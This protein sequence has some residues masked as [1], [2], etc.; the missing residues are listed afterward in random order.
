MCYKLGI[1]IGST[2]IKAV[3]IDETGALIYSTY[4]RHGS[5]IVEKLADIMDELPLLLKGKTVKV[6]ITGSA[7]MSLAESCGI[8][9]VQEVYALSGAVREL[10]PETDVVIEL[11]GEDAKILF[12]TGGVEERMNGTCAGGTGAFIDQ[13]ATLLNVSVEELDRLAQNHKKIYPIAS[14]CGVFAK[15]DIQPLINQGAAKED[16]AASIYQAVAEQTITGLAQGRR[17]LGRVLF[18][19]GPLS[20]NLGLRERFIETLNLSPENAVFP[21][22]GQYFVAL[23]AAVYADGQP[24]TFDYKTLR[25]VLQNQKALKGKSRFLPPLFASETEYADFTARH[26][27]NSVPR[28]DIAAYQGG[29]YL[30]VDVGSTTSKLALVGENGELLYTFYASN[31]GNPL[32]IIQEQLLKVYALLGDHIQLKAGAV[33]GYGEELVKNAFGIDYGLVETVAHFTA[34][35]FFNPNVDYIIDIG[36]QDMK[37]FTIHNNTIDHIVLNEACSSGCGSF[38]QTFAEAL[39]YT[40]SEFARL[41]L[42]AKRPVDLGSRCTVF[43]N[44]SVKQAQRDGAEVADVSAGLAISVVKN[45]IYK[46]LRVHSAKELGENIV[47]QGGTFLND[48]VLRSFERE[49]E[50]DVVRPDI[51]GL[52]G[53]FGAALYARNRHRELGLNKTAMLSRDEV[54]SF[55]HKAIPTTCQGCANHCSLTINIFPNGRRFISGNKCER[56]VSGKKSNLPNV[57][58]YINDKF[59]RLMADAE[60][61]FVPERTTIGIPL[62]LNMW[63]NL[64][65]WYF[66]FLQLGVNV[67]ISGESSRQLYAE[68]QFTIPSDTVCYPA[69]LA[70]G[71]I[72]RLL[73]K[74]VKAIFYPC[75]S[76]NIDEKRGDK[77]YNCP[78]VAYYPEL[79]AANVADLQKVD[80]LYP[81]LS[82]ANRSLLASNFYDMSKKYPYFNFSLAQ[83]INAA[84]DAWNFYKAF[85]SEVEAYGMEALKNAEATGQKIVVLSG[86]P[87]HVDREINH[88]ID[89]M[90]NSLGFVVLSE[91]V[92]TNLAY[93]QKVNVLNQWTYHTR[94]YNAARYV[95]RHPNMQLVQLVS[96]G[97]GLDAITTD[98]LKDILE[99]NGKIYTQL[100]IDEINNLAA[101]KI[102][103]RSL[104][105]AMETREAQHKR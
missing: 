20:F 2:T 25:K 58:E 21:E 102:R 39:G 46:V 9:F 52:M 97:C 48:A 56:G 40:P 92:L 83:C 98:E 22:L 85:W 68:G 10:E 75:S 57:Y 31:K 23:G 91:R 50:H 79:L 93:S 74:N 72:M 26:A 99:R 27:K 71:H 80:F 41:A 86:R 49:L 66:F 24:D 61:Q 36:G 94:M 81:Y 34:A 70:H 13:M 67:V 32:P 6:A 100:K 15:T 53:A 51:A 30:G 78:V 89:K 16:I 42:F 90:F 29:A 1:D 17:I 65:F 60:A 33:T 87:Y 54:A 28:A 88:S 8:P 35:H 4:Q 63:E 44:S 76:Y 55:Q 3:V 82:L 5:R 104:L 12:L 73:A 103:A 18:L 95:C 11:G 105:A 59:R 45:A 47:V 84:N 7:G 77:N 69:K 101:T 38:I 43:M 19:G 96:F 64:P 37:C 62:V 14:R